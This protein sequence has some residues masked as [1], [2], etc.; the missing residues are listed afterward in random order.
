MRRHMFGGGL[1]DTAGEGGHQDGVTDMRW[2][3]V[4]TGAMW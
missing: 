1:L 3:V 2:S 4:L